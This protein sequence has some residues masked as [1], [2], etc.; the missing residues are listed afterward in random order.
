MLLASVW[1]MSL[2]YPLAFLPELEIIFMQLLPRLGFKM[3]LQELPFP[4]GYMTGVHRQVPPGG[5]VHR[6][7][8][9]NFF[10]FMELC[11]KTSSS[12]EDWAKSPFSYLQGPFLLGMY[13][14]TLW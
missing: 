8:G 11:I 9:S 1:R 12:K 10:S 2:D 3:A 5:L 7:R 14:W 6:P 4:Q 13:I